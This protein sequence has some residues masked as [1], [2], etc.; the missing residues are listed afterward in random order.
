M[1][2]RVLFDPRVVEQARQIL[3]EVKT[4][5]GRCSEDTFHEVRFPFGEI[6]PS[7]RWCTSLPHQYHPLSGFLTL[8]AVWSHSDL[9]AL[10]HATSACRI[11]TFRVF[12][13]RPAAAP[14]GAS[15]SPAVERDSR[16]QRTGVG[17]RATRCQHL[18][19]ICSFADSGDCLRGRRNPFDCDQRSWLNAAT[20]SAS[21]S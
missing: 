20:L 5:E 6:S 2:R 7:D 3:T 16:D 13:T 15:S 9:V 17:H 8:S 21:E 12:P 4:S 18:K 1:S 11:S 19:T 10:F 14:F